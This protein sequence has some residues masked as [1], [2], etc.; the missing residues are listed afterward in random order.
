VEKLQTLV[1][2]LRADS[3]FEIEEAGK[4]E[5]GRPIHHVR[6]GTGSLKAM[7]V[8]FPHPN[9]PIGGLTVFSL[10]TLLSQRNRALIDADVEW[11]IVPCID[12]DGAMLNEG[13]SQKAFTLE[14]YM[15][16]FHRQEM[17]D[18]VECSFPIRYKRLEFNRPIKE[19]RILMGLLTQVRPDFYYSLH[20][21]S[22]AGGAWLLL[23]RDI[24]QKYHRELYKLLETYRIPLQVTEPFRAGWLTRFGEGI[25]ENFSTTKMYDLFEQ[26]TS[27]P[28]G[29]LQRGAMSFDYIAQLKDSAMSFVSELPYVRHPSAGSKKET[30]QNLRQLKLRM[31]ADNK[32]VATLILEEWEK[33]KGDLDSSSPFYRKIVAG[34]ISA[35]EKLPEGLRTWPAMTQD[36]LFNPAYGKKAT[37]GERFDV[38]L[39]D[40]FFALCHS[41]EFVRLLRASTQTPAVRQAAERLERVFDEALRELAKEID[42]DEFEVLDC[43]SLARVQFGAGLIVLNS[44]LESKAS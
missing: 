22:G 25:Y 1:E 4:S 30:T 6:F 41:Y 42:L 27:S 36:I 13:W 14:R 43:D 31:D 40:R 28:E 20:N 44:V 17:R 7:F 2:T 33:V 19:T 8:G 39:I 18:Q 24:G 34:I 38:Y 21:N 32:F 5:N 35:K 10:L 11:H 12:P 26:T 3:S 29:S 16:N 37:E 23:T 15:R 9:E